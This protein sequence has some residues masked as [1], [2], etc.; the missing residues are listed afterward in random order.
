MALLSQMPQETVMRGLSLLQ[1]LLTTKNLAKSKELGAWA[2]GLL[3]R[4]RPVGE[5]GSEEVGILRS[6]GKRAVWVLRGMIAGRVDDAMA[7]E[8]VEVDMEAELEG[9]SMAE[10]REMRPEEGHGS[11][12][13]GGHAE[14]QESF[15]SAHDRSGYLDST[16]A[17]ALHELSPA[18]DAL[19][20]SS[21]DPLGIPP[22]QFEPNENM[23]NGA[24]LQGRQRFLASLPPLPLTTAPATPING[25]SEVSRSEPP[26]A[27]QE[28]IPSMDKEG[29]RH[30]D[31]HVI[32]ATLDMIIT[33]VGKFY[34]QRDLLDGRL[35][36]DEL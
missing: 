11:F 33:I 29:A 23:S 13:E 30:I 32:H 19:G 24:L 3:A 6:L 2:W 36:W 14:E 17:D 18:L 25:I 35:L 12:D 16:G 22:G 20:T 26:P 34:G 4:C 5:M 31:T 27:G 15:P 1:K 8:E 10:L 9:N 28:L 21:I 7:D